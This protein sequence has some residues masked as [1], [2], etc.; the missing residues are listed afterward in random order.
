ML[1]RSG[2]VQFNLSSIY[3]SSNNSIVYANLSI[4][5]WNDGANTAN[6]NNPISLIN[7]QS[8]DIST[9]TANEL[10]VQ[11]YTLET[12]YTTV[13][14]NAGDKWYNFSL[15]SLLQSDLDVPTNQKFIIRVSSPYISGTAPN[16]K[17][18]N[19]NIYAGNMYNN[20]YQKFTSSVGTNPLY[21]TI[22]WYNPPTVSVNDTCTVPVSGN[23]AITCSDNCT[24]SVDQIIPANVTIS[25]NGIIT[26][27][28]NFS[29]RGSGQYLFVNSGCELDINRGGGFN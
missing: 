11:G 9:A 15:T 8:L 17:T 5:R 14:G 16:A 28:A 2:F 29:W 12:N 18:N 19:T 6:Q 13:A 27:N 20:M 23:W 10:Y 26:L 22:M 1:F 24:F 21:L 4:F 25:G 7:N 3:P